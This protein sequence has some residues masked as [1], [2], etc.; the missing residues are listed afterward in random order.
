MFTIASLN[1]HVAARDG[2]QKCILL[3][4]TRRLPFPLALYHS[5]HLIKPICVAVHSRYLKLEHLE[6]Q[7]FYEE[8]TLLKA[9]ECGSTN[10]KARVLQHNDQSTPYGH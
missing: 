10:V 7:G 8:S 5:Y 4:V 9:M 3:W 6:L 1:N 2:Q